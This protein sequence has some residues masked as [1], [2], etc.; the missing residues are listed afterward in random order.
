MGRH[1][2]RELFIFLIGGILIG[3]LFA[4]LGCRA[5]GAPDRQAPKVPD[6]IPNVGGLSNWGF[7]E[8]NG[9]KLKIV[10][11]PIWEANGE[12]R[13]DGTVVL[14]WHVVYDDCGLPCPDGVG[15]Y[16]IDGK[17]LV[18]RWG[19]ADGSCWIDDE[20]VLWGIH[21]EDRVYK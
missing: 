21:E 14:Y 18:G 1:S 20:G 16:S 13:D 19:W 11:H 12:V 6:V 17:D 10:G 15:V 2:A 8:Q 5:D 7:V 4:F 9:R 3:F